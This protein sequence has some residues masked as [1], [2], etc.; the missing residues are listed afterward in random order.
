[1]YLNTDYKEGDSKF[2]FDTTIMCNG[3][4]YTGPSKF[5]TGQLKESLDP[6]TGQIRVN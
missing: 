6:I 2:G 5:M 4:K 3:M 1:M